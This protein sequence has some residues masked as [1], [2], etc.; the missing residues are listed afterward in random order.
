MGPGCGKDARF[1]SLFFKNG[2]SG[3]RNPEI[4]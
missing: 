2:P 1:E 4:D 3:R